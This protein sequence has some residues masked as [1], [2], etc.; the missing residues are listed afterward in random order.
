MELS[1]KG[2]DIGGERGRDAGEVGEGTEVRVYVIHGVAQP[3]EATTS[4]V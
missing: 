4:D 2:C 3:P 1:S